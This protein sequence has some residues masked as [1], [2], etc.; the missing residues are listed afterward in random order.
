M[1]DKELN[2][3]IKIKALLETYS[4]NDISNTFTQ[5]DNKLLSLHECSSEDFLQLNKVFMNLYKQSQIISNNV[6]SIVNV[7]S[8]ETDKKLYNEVQ[9]FYDQLKS[10]ADIYDQKITLIMKFLGELSN[11]LRYIFFPIKNF[12]QNLMSLKYLIANLNLALSITHDIKGVSEELKQ[13]ENKLNDIKA[14]TDKILKSLNHLRKISKITY[15]NFLQIKEQNE[16]IVSSLLMNVKSKIS[17]IE[18]KYITSKECIP[19]IQ[20]KTE[21]SEKSISDITRKLQYQDIIKQ[22]MEHIQD[23]HKELMVELNKFEESPND[24]KHAN[25]KAKFFLRIRDI[26]GL[27]AAQL[28]QANKEYQSALEMIVNNFMKVGDNM[29]AISEMCGVINAEENKDEVKLFEEI[30]E[31][32]SVSENNFKEK[33]DQNSKLKNDIALIERKI[34]QSENYL[35]NLKEKTNNLNHD[36]E[37][38]IIKISQEAKGKVKVED[39]LGQ[40]KKLY[41]EVSNNVGHIENLTKD[42]EPIKKR[43]KVFLTEYKDLSFEADFKEIKDVVS[44]LYSVRNDLEVKLQENHNIS[45]NALES[46]KKSISEIKYYD[47]F[48]NII[49]EIISELNTINYNL[50]VDDDIKEESVEENLKKIKK[51]Y[52]METEHKIHEQVSKGEDVDFEI[53]NDEDGDIEFF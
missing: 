23:T 27:Q 10:Q 41:E 46:I 44:K 36:I 19:F 29:K 14:L 2:D 49:E 42:V 13:L 37:N 20:K 28:I 8:T 9:L 43:I 48:E 12:A 6:H 24:D 47:F 35:N 1:S 50:K 40:V 45:N 53:D 3:K 26:A 5:I 52:T 32:I 51:Y 25:D 7:F 31:Q 4:V 33:V 21:K 22:K 17:G 18:L 15:S 30:V 16:D 11:K 38:N 39:S 34:M